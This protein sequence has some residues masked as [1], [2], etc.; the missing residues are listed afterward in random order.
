MRNRRDVADAVEAV[1]LQRHRSDRGKVRDML[2]GRTTYRLVRTGMHADGVLLCILVRICR[3]VAEH[4]LV[5]M[6]TTKHGRPGF[7]STD[8]VHQLHLARPHI[9]L[10]DSFDHITNLPLAM[11]IILSR[12]FHGGREHVVA[13]EFVPDVVADSEMARVTSSV[14]TS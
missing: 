5:D 11:I 13:V 14:T 3:S 7:R 12:N 2:I 4:G 1:S 9:F 8:V 6:E 10:F